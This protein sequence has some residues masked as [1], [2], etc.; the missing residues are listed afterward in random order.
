MSLWSIPATLTQNHVA[1]NTVDESSERNSFCLSDTPNAKD[2]YSY[3][4][5][6]RQLGVSECSLINSQNERAELSNIFGG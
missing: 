5:A 3:H 1:C 2:V 4:S 6:M